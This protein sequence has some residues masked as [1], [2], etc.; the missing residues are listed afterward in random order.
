MRTKYS[1]WLNLKPGNS[2]STDSNIRMQIDTLLMKNSSLQASLG[3]DSTK[4][5]KETVKRKTDELMALIKDIDI[6]FYNLIEP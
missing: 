6:N 1:E 4:E 5:E 3:S 2:Y